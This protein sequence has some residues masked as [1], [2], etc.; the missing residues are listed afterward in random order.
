MEG[1]R[2]ENKENVKSVRRCDWRRGRKEEGRRRQEGGK[3]EVRRKVRR[4]KGRKEGRKAPHNR[5]SHYLHKHRLIENK[6]T[7]GSNC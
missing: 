1:S 4:K 6:A 7:P 3:K 5:S 2:E